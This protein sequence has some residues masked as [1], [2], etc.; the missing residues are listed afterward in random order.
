M[1]RGCGSFQ[2]LDPLASP[3]QPSGPAVTASLPPWPPS[4]FPCAGD[5]TQISKCSWL[6]A[7]VMLCSKSDKPLREQLF[8]ATAKD[9]LLGPKL[10]VPQAAGAWV[11][12]W[13]ASSEVERETLLMLLT[14]RTR[15]Q[16]RKVAFARCLDRRGWSSGT[17]APW[18]VL[19]QRHTQVGTAKANDPSKR[20][21]PNRR[22]TSVAASH[23]YT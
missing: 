1:L 21:A 22:K 8:E 12:L 14:S 9:G 13:L 7:R 11:R 20:C 19:A 16:V 18:R 23:L 6:A 2:A 4:S 17:V 3:A 5:A 15:L 10:P